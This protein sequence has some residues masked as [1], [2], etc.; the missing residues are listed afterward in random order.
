[1]PCSDPGVT[2]AAVGRAVKSLKKNEL[3][4]CA[5]FSTQHCGDA[6]LIACEA[7]PP[8]ECSS[9]AGTHL[10]ACEGAVPFLSSCGWSSWTGAGTYWISLH[11][12]GLRTL[13]VLSMTLWY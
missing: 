11:F 4:A 8:A 13:C 2:A 3:D 1:M 10:K 7:C 9:S 6:G 12:V 5:W